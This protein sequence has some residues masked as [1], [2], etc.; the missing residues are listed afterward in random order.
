VKARPCEEMSR[1]IVRFDEH[2]TVYRVMREMNPGGKQF[3]RSMGI[4]YPR[5]FP[6]RINAKVEELG[7]KLN[8]L[9]EKLE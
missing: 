4:P 6:E 5:E 3:P 1:L 2:V 7:K 8:T 9:M